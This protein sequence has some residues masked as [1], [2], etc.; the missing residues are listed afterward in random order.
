MIKFY[1]FVEKILSGHKLSFKC[2]FNMGLEALPRNFN[3]TG[4]QAAVKFH[5]HCLHLYIQVQGYV[6]R[7]NPLRH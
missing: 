5:V 2:V 6:T 4:A 3:V 1:R 7:L